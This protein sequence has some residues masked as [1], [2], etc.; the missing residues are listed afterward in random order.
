MTNLMLFQAWVFSLVGL[1]W[2]EGLLVGGLL[3]W[4]FY[5]VMTWV[6]AYFNARRPI[7]SSVP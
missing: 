6:E 4:V 1:A 2:S 5:E 7:A 3:A